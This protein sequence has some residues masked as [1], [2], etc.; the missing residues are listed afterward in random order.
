MMK[1]LKVLYFSV[2]FMM[3]F[4]TTSLA[5]IDPATSTYVIQIIA[6]VFIASGIAIGIYWQKFKRFIR[7][8]M[9]KK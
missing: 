9:K 3:L 4:T 7:K 8:I 5:Y 1:L 2:C 6:G